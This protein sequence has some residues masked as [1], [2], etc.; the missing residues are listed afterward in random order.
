MCVCLCCLLG[1][2]GS[3]HER[4]VSGPLGA[5]ASGPMRLPLRTTCTPPRG[6]G[7]GNAPA[8]G[9]TYGRRWIR[10]LG[11]PAPLLCL[12]SPAVCVHAVRVLRVLVQAHTH[13]LCSL[14]C[15]PECS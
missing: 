13:T 9:P 11:S 7:P 15:L 4:L 6:W 14:R 12:P 2:G 5:C 10:V 8:L 1:G 3:T